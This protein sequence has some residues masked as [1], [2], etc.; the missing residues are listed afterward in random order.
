MMAWIKLQ[1]SVISAV[2]YQER[3][4]YIRFT[5]NHEYK[6]YNVPKKNYEALLQAA[7]A[8]QYFNAYIKNY[9]SGRKIS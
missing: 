4:L 2:A 3:T 1:S 5:S 9:Y 8:G 7:S 6:Y